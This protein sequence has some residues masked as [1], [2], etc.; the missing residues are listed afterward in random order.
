MST[1]I[2]MDFQWNQL[3]GVRDGMEFSVFD[4]DVDVSTKLMTIRYE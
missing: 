3:N 4:T 2:I 1:I